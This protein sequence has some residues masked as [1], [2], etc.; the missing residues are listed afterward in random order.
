[1]YSVDYFPVFPW[2][3]VFLI[4]IFLGNVLYPKYERRIQIPDLS[5]FFVV[6]F[7]CFLGRH[8][9]TIYLLHQPILILLLYVLG[10]AD[11][12]SLRLG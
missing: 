4:G 2:F 3:G 9:L 12:G 1:M 7:F 8:S 5:R 10:V 6:R 11:L